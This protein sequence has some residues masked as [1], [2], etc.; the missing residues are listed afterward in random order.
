MCRP[1]P[2]ALAALFACI[3][4]LPAA[5]SGALRA[6]TQVRAFGTVARILPNGFTIVLDRARTDHS[7]AWAKDPITVTRSD[8]TRMVAQNPRD[9]A[10]VRVGTQVEVTGES[11]NGNGSQI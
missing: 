10:T 2:Y 7:I 1:T 4:L 5:S 6:L 11:W 9:Q 3:V 8:R